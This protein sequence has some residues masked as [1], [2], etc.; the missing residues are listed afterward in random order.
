MVLSVILFLI[1]VVSTAYFVVYMLLVGLTN[2]FTYFWI[3]LGVVG[4]AGGTVCYVLY[5]HQVVFPK[6]FS[7]GMTIV[8]GIVL[9][10]FLIVEGIIIGYGRSKPQPGADYV[11]VL[12]ARVRGEQVTANLARRLW[13]AC[14]YLE[15]NPQTNVILSGGQGQGE[16]ISEAEAMKCYLEQRG[17][18]PE[19][20]ILEDKSVNTDQN[21]SYS[22]EKM[23]GADK[24]VV[25]VSNDFHIFRSLLIAKKKGM[26]NVQ[27]CGSATKWYTVPNMYVRE[28]FAVIKYAACGQI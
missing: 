8:I 6:W 16:D 3:L 11:I 7:R 1:G 12:G 18:A 13:A 14:D 9:L 10:L 27:G 2:V 28:A 15:E 25:I 19:R 22:M 17:I 23:E 24:S 4:M 26:K 5:R 21:L 20:M